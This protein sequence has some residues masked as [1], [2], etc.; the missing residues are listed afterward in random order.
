M[1]DFD[2]EQKIRV[3]ISMHIRDFEGWVGAKPEGDHFAEVP[4]L[5]IIAAAAVALVTIDETL[6]AG[7]SVVAR[8]RNLY[9]KLFKGQTPADMTPITLSE[10][11]IM[12]LAN[13]RAA[14][15]LGL[16]ERQLAT[17]TMAEEEAVTMELARL[18]SFSVAI[19]SED[20]WTLRTTE[21]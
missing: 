7:E 17:I 8:L 13:E 2:E 18:K 3:S 6:T 16:T 14:H 5:E 19:F 1:I 20:Y 4:W 15:G 21:D 9:K 11:I 12:E 10:R